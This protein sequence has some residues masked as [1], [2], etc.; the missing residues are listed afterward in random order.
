MEIDF[1]KDEYEMLVNLGGVFELNKTIYG[2][3]FVKFE[4]VQYKCKNYNTAFP[5]AFCICCYEN[6]GSQFLIMIEFSSENV[7][8]IEYMTNHNNYNYNIQVNETMYEIYLEEM[9]KYKALSTI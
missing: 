7:V 3:Y 4:G 6:I 9:Q 8:K 1:S 5:K 2:N